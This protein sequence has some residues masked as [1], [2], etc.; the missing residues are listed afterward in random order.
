MTDYYDES[1]NFLY[2]EYYEYGTIKYPVQYYGWEEWKTLMKKAFPNKNRFLRIL[3]RGFTDHKKI[4]LLD[5]NH[6]YGKIQAD[7]LK[8]HELGHI[9]GIPHTWRPYVNNPTWLLRWSR[10]FYHKEPLLPIVRV[11][12]FSMGSLSQPKGDSSH[13]PH[14]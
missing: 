10:K 8:K 3:T 12:Q 1:K 13:T 14:L 11:V 2:D 4:Y 9:I 6:W 7:K 5:R